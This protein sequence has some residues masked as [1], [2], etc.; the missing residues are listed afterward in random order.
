MK[1]SIFTALIFLSHGGFPLLHSQPAW[2]LKIESFFVFQIVHSKA[3]EQTFK[4]LQLSTTAS[5][6]IQN[7]FFLEESVMSAIEP[8]SDW[9]TRQ[10]KNKWVT[11]SVS[12]E[13][14]HV[15]SSNFIFFWI[16][17]VKLCCINQFI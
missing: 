16:D 3:V 14:R 12:L 9:S 6:L 1:L 10:S 11:G 8:H 2:S 15:L 5:P 17:S 13:N 7:N 4:A